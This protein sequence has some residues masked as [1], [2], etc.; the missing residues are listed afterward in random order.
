MK[1]TLASL[2]IFL[3]FL[4]S[5]CCTKNGCH[6]KPSAYKPKTFYLDVGNIMIIDDSYSDSRQESN[7]FV[8]S[9]L[10]PDLQRWVRDH[11]VAH[12]KKG[13]ALIRVIDGRVT[14]AEVGE[15]REER[16]M[17]ANVILSVEFVDAGSNLVGKITVR[18][19]AEKRFSIS[20]WSLEHQ[21]EVRTS[22]WTQI[23]ERM[24]QQF[25]DRFMQS[26]LVKGRSGAR[27]PAP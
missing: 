27:D 7:Q 16:D 11:F 23:T 12:G 13:R 6:K 5:G 4:V 8:P 26:K 9:T 17:Q 25:Y 3:C 20:S 15:G 24:E 1:I 19:T 10:V 21:N 2:L 14:M 22:L 18:V